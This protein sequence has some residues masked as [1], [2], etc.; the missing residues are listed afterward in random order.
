MLTNQLVRQRGATEIYLLRNVDDPNE[1]F[2]LSQVGDL[3]KAR[4][5]LAS[6][7]LREQMQQSGVVDK[8]DIYFL[9]T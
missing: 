5:F 7:D 2:L 1:I 6:A 4:E 8:T 3:E 9:T